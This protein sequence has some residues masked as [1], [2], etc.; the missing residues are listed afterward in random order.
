ML[1]GGIQAHHPTNHG[2]SMGKSV[3]DHAQ[4]IL[5]AFSAKCAKFQQKMQYMPGM[6]RSETHN[7]TLPLDVP[8]DRKVLGKGGGLY[9]ANHKTEAKTIFTVMLIK[10]NTKLINK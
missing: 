10:H 2:R 3:Q 7:V 9:L 6:L 1:P 8:T 5:Y 4:G